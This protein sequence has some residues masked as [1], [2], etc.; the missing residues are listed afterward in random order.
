MIP[1]SATSNM[2]PP[3]P[4]PS[5]NCYHLTLLKKFCHKNVSKCYDC[6]AL[7]VTDGYPKEPY[8]LVIVLKNQRSYVDPK[9]RQ[10]TISSDFSNVYFHFNESCVL[11]HDSCFTPQAVV[12]PEELKQHL[13]IFHKTF[14]DSLRIFY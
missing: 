2:T 6:Q 11:K 8:D 12:V 1:V 14:L 4:N 3:S 5:Q 9:A 10:K 13:S 7:F